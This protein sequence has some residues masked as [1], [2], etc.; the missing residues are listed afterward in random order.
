MGL[1]RGRW[2]WAALAWLALPAAAHATD[3]AV[4]VMGVNARG[5]SVRATVCT[6]ANFLQPHCRYSGRTVAGSGGAVTVRVAGVPPGTYAVQVFHDV[7]DNGRITQNL[8]GIPTEGV[9]FSRD[10]PI[11]FGPP[12]FADAEIA[13]AG[14]LVTIDINLKFEP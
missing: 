14:A 13:V 4:R 12:R 10:A 5:G 9:G 8:F 2:A 3:I 1:F 11:R 7:D 6:Q